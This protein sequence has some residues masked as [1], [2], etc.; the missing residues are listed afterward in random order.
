MGVGVDVGVCVCV[1]VCVYRQ[2]ILCQLCF[3]SS[4]FRGMHSSVHSMCSLN[5]NTLELPLYNVCRYKDVLDA[6]AALS[7]VILSKQQCSHRLSHTLP[8]IG[9]HAAPGIQYA[10]A[11]LAIWQSGGIVVPLGTSFPPTELSHLF[12]DAGIK[13]VRCHCMHGACPWMGLAQQPA[14]RGMPLNAYHA[15]LS[16]PLWISHA[17][18]GLLLV[19][20]LLLVVVLL[21]LLLLVLVLLLLLLSHW[22]CFWM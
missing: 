17:L 8:R 14:A 15:L 3:S 22:E 1:R 4:P 6:S 20:L 18:A 19:V 12:Q 5:P 16:Q 21:P 10:V 7:R 11:T 2:Q 13:L 9:L